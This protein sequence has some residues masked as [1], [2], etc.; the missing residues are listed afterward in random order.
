MGDSRVE[1][2]QIQLVPPEEFLAAKVPVSDIAVYTASSAPIGC[3]DHLQRVVYAPYHASRTGFGEQAAVFALTRIPLDKPSNTVS[4]VLL[5]SDEV[6]DGQSY[7]WPIDGST[8]F[9]NGKVRVFFLANGDNYYFMD[10]NPVSC[11]RS[12]IGQ[13]KCRRDGINAE[14]L[15]A[16]AVQ[17]YLESKGMSG[18][19]LLFDSHE[20]I[21][22]TAKP[23]WETTDDGE[24]TGAFYGAI[25]SGQ[26]QPI[27]YRCEDGETFDFLGCIPELASYECQVAFLNGIIYAL[28]RGAKGDNFWFSDDGGHHFQPAG[29][30]EM[31]ETRPQLMAFQG[32]IL[33]GY[34]EK[35]ISPNRVRD[36]RNNLRILL[37]KGTDLSAYDKIYELTDP[38]GF[39]YFDFIDC[40]G[41]ILA[42]WSNSERY[43]DKPVWGCLQGKDALFCSW[44]MRPNGR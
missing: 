23:A 8:I 16:S 12:E 20:H 38:I 10:W 37:G 43:P 28:L 1:E 6:V 2:S 27:I 17:A 36:G 14:P 34:S 4:Y 41:K 18:F 33:I 44:L 24:R 35:G 25:T 40:D 26:A 31:S 7:H 13:V 3:Y 42:I 21:I 11:K 5:E 30:L 9:R 15:T 22:N 39:V 19:N 29:H 32:K